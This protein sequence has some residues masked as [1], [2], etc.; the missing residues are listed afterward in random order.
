MR[1]VE[2]QDI[3][4]THKN[5]SVRVNSILYRQHSIS[6]TVT[7]ITTYRMYR[8]PALR[9]G[10]FRR[11]GG[12]RC[13]RWCVCARFRFHGHDCV[14]VVVVVRSFTHK[15]AAVGKSNIQSILVVDKRDG[16]GNEARDAERGLCISRWVGNDCSVTK[17]EVGSSV[18]RESLDVM[19]KARAIGNNASYQ[20]GV[21]IGRSQ[22]WLHGSQERGYTS[23]LQNGKSR[24]VFAA[25]KNSKSFRQ[26]A[27]SLVN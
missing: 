1:D 2:R 4:G 18:L 13:R 19:D 15:I 21:R 7:T 27:D 12:N 23:K 17:N 20:Y 3:R 24:V 8:N 14:V 16:G 6:F 5:H 10:L 9:F 26:S 11:G 22:K 25:G